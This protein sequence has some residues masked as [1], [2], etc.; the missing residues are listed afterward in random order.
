MQF[1][2]PGD[3]EAKNN[4]ENHG[5]SEEDATEDFRLRLRKELVSRD[6]HG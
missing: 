4:L 6:G 5:R 1:A 3:E 2:T